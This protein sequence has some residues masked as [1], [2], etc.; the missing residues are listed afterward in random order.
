TN[1][2]GARP[3]HRWSDRIS[4]ATIP[5]P[6]A[7][8]QAAARRCLLPPGFAAA[9]LDRTPS[10]A[11]AMEHLRLTSEHAAIPV[12]TV[13]VAAAAITAAEA[14]TAGDMR[15]SGYFRRFPFG[16]LTVL[17]LAIP[18]AASSEFFVQT[19]FSSAEEG[20]QAFVEAIK[21]NDPSVLQT[22]LGPDGP[23]L[24]DSG[25]AAADAQWRKRFLNT[26]A[27]ANKVVLKGNNTRAILTVGRDEWPMPIPL[28]KS[29]KGWRFDTPHAAEEI[30]N[31]HIGRNEL[32]AI[33]VCLAIVDAEREYAT[34]DADGDG[35]PGFASKFVSSPGKRDGLY[36]ETREDEPLSPVGPLL[37]AAANEGPVTSD[38][39]VLTPFH[40]Y[41]Y[42]MLT[43][44]G[45]NAPGGAYDYRANGKLLGGF[46]VLA[47]PARYGTS[48]VVSFMVNQDGVVYQK[49]L[50]QNTAALVAEITE[51]DPDPSWRLAP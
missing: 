9:N 16:I 49:D 51:F 41:L 40:G 15:R 50:G 14:I 37:A 12:F 26:Y 29:E 28:V 24:F 35:V 38:S 19:T 33:Q 8:L 30:L 23:K 34:Q 42:R 43:K 25:D 7:A 5:L 21:L 20:M 31:R 47:Y 27:D 32:A 46:A 18:S 10:K 45:K 2:M 44:Q 48:G 17:L 22:L 13:A 1:S 6:A 39:T 4:A 11:S 36:W 3:P